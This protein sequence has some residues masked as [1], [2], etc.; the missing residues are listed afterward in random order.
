MSKVHVY[1]RELYED[2]QVKLGV[3]DK[4]T[5]VLNEAFLEAVR[6]LLVLEFGEEFRIQAVTLLIDHKRNA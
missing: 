3:G 4:P 6:P 2:R 5:D 1:T